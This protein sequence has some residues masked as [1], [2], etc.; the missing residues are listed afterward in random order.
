MYLHDMTNTK[1][2]VAAISDGK[3][4]P[5][6]DNLFLTSSYDGTIRQWDLFGKPVGME[7]NL[8]HSLLIKTRD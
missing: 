8:G 5:K 3:W 2:H 4:N 1:G 6:N 7:Q